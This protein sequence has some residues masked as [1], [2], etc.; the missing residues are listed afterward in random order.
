MIV[1]KKKINRIKNGSK[2]KVIYYYIVDSFGITRR[3]NGKYVD[4]DLLKLKDNIII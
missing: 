4:K 1:L 2:Q 3:I